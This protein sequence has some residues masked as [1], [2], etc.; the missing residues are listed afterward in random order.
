[1]VILQVLVE[2]NGYMV[3]GLVAG[4]RAGAQS[5]AFVT[6]TCSSASWTPAPTNARIRLARLART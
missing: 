5:A 6:W 2:T 3:G 1:M 4:G